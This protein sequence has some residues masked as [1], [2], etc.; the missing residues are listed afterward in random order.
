LNQRAEH[1]L[2]GVLP[3]PGKITNKMKWAQ[4]ERSAPN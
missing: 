2:F 3:E 1:N 4:Q